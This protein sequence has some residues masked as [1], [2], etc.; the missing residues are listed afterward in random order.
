MATSIGPR[1]VGHIVIRYDKKRTPKYYVTS[2]P[3]G[4][5]LFESNS[6]D[7]AV[8]WAINRYNYNFAMTF[9][10]SPGCSHN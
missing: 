1:V 3:P 2:E 8:Q 6:A 4:K 7:E 9:P 5:V 10:Y